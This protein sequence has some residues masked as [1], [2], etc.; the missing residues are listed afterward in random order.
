MMIADVDL[1]TNMVN[2]GGIG[3]LAAV[4]FYLHVTAMKNF[5]QQQDADRAMFRDELRIEREVCERRHNALESKL[6]QLHSDI[7]K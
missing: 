6:D 7:R 1:P 2:F 4:L 3:V 5:A